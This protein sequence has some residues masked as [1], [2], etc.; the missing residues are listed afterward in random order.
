MIKR[1]LHTLLV[2]LAFAGVLRAQVNLVPNPSFE[3]YT[4][5]PDF[6]GQITRAQNWYSPT[7][8]TPDYY[9]SCSTELYSSVPVN[10]N[11]FQYPKTG[12]AYC[13]VGVLLV[14]DSREYIQCQ[15]TNELIADKY[16]CL[17]YYVSATEYRTNYFIKNID[18]FLSTDEVSNFTDFYPILNF[19]PQIKN[20]EIIQDSVSWVLI[21][22]MYLA[23]GG[24]RYL[25]I[26]NFLDSNNTEY[27]QVNNQNGGGAM[28]YIDDVSIIEISMPLIKGNTNICDGDTAKLIAEGDIS[29]FAWFEENN[30]GVVL[31]NANTLNIFPTQPTTYVLKSKVCNSEIETKVIVDVCNDGQPFIGL[32]PNPTSDLLNINLHNLNPIGKTL[33][34]YNAV[35]QLVFTENINSDIYTINTASLANGVYTVAVLD[36]KKH[37]AKEKFVVLH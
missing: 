11:G 1:L 4:D 15:L 9:N 2:L 33:L 8:G 29:E 31:S 19:I 16:Y 25:T 13:S 18:A 20:D 7:T 23:Q 5:C 12:N 17:S 21:Q 32:Y 27:I 26:G 35:G 34:I 36:S 3:I 6:S 30:P 24:E 28:V 10:K 37:L 14:N 22:G